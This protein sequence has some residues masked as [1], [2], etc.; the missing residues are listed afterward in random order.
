MVTR[1]FI[2]M[3]AVL[4]GF[5]LLLTDVSRVESQSEQGLRIEI[6][7]QNSKFV[8]TQPANLEKGIPTVLILRNQDIVRHGFTSPMLAGMHVEGEAGGMAVYG[9]GIEG[10]YVDPWKTLVLR[11][12]PMHSGRYEF[13]CDIHP[14]M[15][16]EV[17]LLEMNTA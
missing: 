16:G 9:K 6:S 13:R 10:F 5:F 3:M 17:F 8:L 4:T 12:T 2:M 11:F 1:P 7:I 14:G 15:K